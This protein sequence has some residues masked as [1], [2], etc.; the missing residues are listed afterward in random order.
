VVKPV[1]APKAVPAPPAPPAEAQPEPIASEDAEESSKES[2]EVV[3]QS[4]NSELAAQALDQPEV[5]PDQ[6]PKAPAPLD[7][8]PDAPAAEVEEESTFAASAEEP[9]QTAEV[10]PEEEASPVEATQGPWQTE[11]QAP[12]ANDSQESAQSAVPSQSSPQAIPAAAYNGPPGLNPAGKPS[13]AAPVR[14]SSR[15]ASRF[16]DGKAVVMPGSTST[17]AGL[18]MQFGS[19]SFGNASAGPEPA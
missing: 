13:A 1:A 6:E 11:A 19:L 18:D 14:T 15:A 5:I 8:V 4:E 2:E 3:Q 9:V 16:P 10:T 7:A 12:A 17:G